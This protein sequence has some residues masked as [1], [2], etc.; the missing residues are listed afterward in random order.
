MR[1]RRKTRLRNYHPQVNNNR[2]K[3][4]QKL[5]N[6]KKSCLSSLERPHPLSKYR[7]NQ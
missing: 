5:N 4:R 7:L 2:K 3:R 1:T 6:N